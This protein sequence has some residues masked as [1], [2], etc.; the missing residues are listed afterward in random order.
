[1]RIDEQQHGA[2][3]IIKPQGALIEADTPAIKARLIESLSANHG[4]FVLD[5]SAAPF[6]DSKGLEMLLEI[7][8]Q[9]AGFGQTLRLCSASKTIR[10]V[11]DITDLA[12]LFDQFDDATTAVRSFL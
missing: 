2:V 9:M 5:L 12:G 11:L 10:E 4:R 1:M 8:E 3:K 6:I 7:S